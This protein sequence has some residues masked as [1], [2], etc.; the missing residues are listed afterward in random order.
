MDQLN[1][2]RAFLLSAAVAS[3]A[4]C[5]D[6]AR[7]PE[8]DTRSTFRTHS[9]LITDDEFA[10]EL[11][12]AAAVFGSPDDAAGTLQLEA[13]PDEFPSY[14]RSFDPDDAFVSVFVSTKQLTRAGHTSRHCPRVT[15]DADRVTYE[16][17]LDARLEPVDDN[18]GQYIRS[19][20]W[21]RHGA[22]APASAE[23]D[24]RR[25]DPGDEAVETCPGDGYS[26]F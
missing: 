6:R 2:R 21:R 24:V 22:D 10:D 4:G 3:T 14:L 18:G 9:P 19:E 16:L 17:A 8:I 20:K 23:V 7:G 12:F 25:P 13:L 11:P 26:S 5:L 1:S 15:V